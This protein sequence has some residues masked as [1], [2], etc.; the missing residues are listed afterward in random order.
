[1]INLADFKR[2]L[3]VQIWPVNKPVPNTRTAKVDKMLLKKETEKIA[4]TF[5]LQ[6]IVILKKHFKIRL[7]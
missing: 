1:M 2:L 7:F 3:F 6:D 5:L 4:E